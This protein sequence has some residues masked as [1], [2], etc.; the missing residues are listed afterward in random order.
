MT[1]ETTTQRVSFHIAWIS[2]AFASFIAVALVLAASWM[3]REVDTAALNEQKAAVVSDLSNLGRRVQ[4]E[5]STASNRK[6]GVFYSDHSNSAW[7]PKTLAEWVSQEF[8]HDRTY[9]FY[10]GGSVL[11]A[12]ADGLKVGSEIRAVDS[13]A[14]TSI[15]SQAQADKTRDADTSWSVNSCCI[16][17]RKLGDGSIALVSVR[18][19]DRFSM[20]KF[21][22]SEP[23][24]LLASVILLDDQAMT[25]MSERL[26]LQG[27]QIA[28]SSGSEATVPLVDGQGKQLAL[29]QWNAPE[30]AAALFQRIALPTSLV[31][32]VVGSCLFFLLAWL[33]RV[34]L[35]L[36][37]S[38]KQAN[39]LALHDTLT[40]LPNRLMFEQ[41]LREAFQ[42]RTLAETKVLLIAVDLDRFKDVNDTHGH[43]AGDELLQNVA[44]R[45]LT[46]L[47]EEATLCRLG[48]D[49]FAI[50]QPGI[51]SD[52]HARWICQRLMQ[53]LS[54]PISLG[55]SMV[56]A[57]V[58]MGFAVEPPSSVTPPELIRR[59]DIALYVSKTEGRNRYTLYDPNMD[60]A[61]KE[62]LT[63]GVELRNALLQDQLSL[64]YQPIFNAQDNRICGVEALLRWQH[65]ERGAVSPELFIGVAE[66]SGF[67]H[68]LGMWVLRQACLFAA[69]AEL[70]WVAVNVS[71]VQFSRERFADEIL[72]TLKALDF[73]PSKLEVEITEGVLLQSSPQI[74]SAL[75][76]LRHAGV[77]IAIDDFGAGYAS[78]SYLRSYPID[79]IKIDRSLIAQFCQDKSL[80]HIVRAI[81][82]MGKAM[83]FT[84]TAEGVEYAEQREVLAG[85][86]CNQLQGYLLS[87]PLKEVQLAHLIQTDEDLRRA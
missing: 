65:P 71:P 28:T 22:A 53:A 80:R 16:G 20:T 79:K 84:I 8:R 67:I 55:T 25:T 38:Q 37:R 9:I 74:Q 86:G 19:L 29:L 51:V 2:F 4:V 72:A 47:P 52:G 73:E 59:A 46:E 75:T 13:E 62:R 57:T 10:Q 30:P 1:K 82:E 56:T 14:I 48:G 39:F 68:E 31:L 83:N 40:G 36:E 41:R 11:Q 32:V 26:G 70:P 78:I 21:A 81:I 6:D 43:G 60:A 77:R 33:R 17:I 66:E 7:V 12:S 44:R 24:L 64:A 61:R 15:A 27:L 3:A 54:H 87:R 85:M 49:E 34:S 69:K 50:V 42:Y 76:K 23:L 63:L 45:L 5:Q 35:R 58:S 18:S